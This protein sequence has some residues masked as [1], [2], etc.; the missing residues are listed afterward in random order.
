[1]RHIA[2]F[3]LL[4]LI[5]SA[6]QPYYPDLAMTPTQSIAESEDAL[7]RGEYATAVTGFSD[8]LSTGQQTFRARAFYQLAQ[9]QYGLENYEA[10]L[11]TLNDMEADYPGTNWPQISAL[12]GDINY[13]LGKRVEAVLDWEKAWE[14]GSETDQ[15]FLRTRIEE[16]IDEL[17]PEEA[18]HLAGELTN[19]DILAMLSTR[20]P[21]AVSAAERARDAAPEPELGT[22]TEPAAAAPLDDGEASLGADDGLGAAP[23][24]SNR[25]I[26]LPSIAAGE[27]LNNGVQVACLLPLTGVDRA[28]GQRALSG[29]RLAF[30][31]FP[32][33]LL[34]RDTG[35]DP[36][37]AAQLTTALADDPNVLV[38]VGPLRTSD[39]S[40]VAPLAERLQMPTLLLARGEGLTG[41]YVL[42]AATTQAQQMSVLAT[43]AVNQMGLQRFGVLYPDDAYGRSYMN[44]F[45]DAAQAAGATLV[46]T[47]AYRPGGESFGPQAAAVKAWTGADAVQ[48]VFIPDAAPTAVRV[49]GAARG[50]APQIALL[51][52]ESWN[53]ADVLAAAGARID[54][55]V[56][57]DSFFAESPGSADFVQRFHSQNGYPPTSLEAQGYDAG[58]LVRE[59]IA[60]GA[61]SRGAMLQSLRTATG[62]Q[63]ALLLLRVQ[64]G[65]IAA[66]GAP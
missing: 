1:M 7:K 43:Y 23:E 37:I 19:A 52:T 46:R 14:R 16:A 11:D 44:S 58:M 41:A 56:F 40:S 32:N 28:S 63:R 45:R 60:Q 64:N 4:G 31:G 26:P 54:G 6:C 17:S 35:S 3:S 2:I 65:H 51:G 12:R 5:V 48:A 47:N 61:Q 25:D 27:A 24:V 8:Y 38:L 22:D 30:Q 10:A 9:A 55:A 50:A 18:A 34:V 62:S 39:A 21:G 20:A 53:Q 15:Q 42:Q 29:L 36:D 57:A 49:A 66:V 59:A 33:T 13:A